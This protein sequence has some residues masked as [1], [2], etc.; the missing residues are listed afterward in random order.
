M[1]E[2]MNQGEN[3]PDQG[4]EAG[5]GAS[6]TADFGQLQQDFN[7]LKSSIDELKAMQTV[8]SQAQVQSQQPSTAEQFAQLTVDQQK[9]LQANP[10]AMLSWLE[11][12]LNRSMAR[13]TN[14]AKAYAEF[15]INQDPKFKAAVIEQMR[16]F[17]N[18]DKLPKDHPTL[19]LRAAQMVAG[20][21]NVGQSSNKV[22]N[23]NAPTSEAPNTIRQQNKPTKIDDSDPRIQF[24]KM[25]GYSRDPKKL[26]AFKAQ[27]GPYVASQRPKGRRLTRE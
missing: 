6:G 22:Q 2:E 3:T 19:L 18:V 9:E 11:G 7:T 4:T 20:R 17:V 21:M 16:E 23:R 8:A 15:P 14:D 25:S 10:A 24:F 12:H 26:E 13:Q 1:D 5:Q 27:L